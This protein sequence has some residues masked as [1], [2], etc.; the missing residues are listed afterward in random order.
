MWVKYPKANARAHSAPAVRPPGVQ[1]GLVAVG[2][3]LMLLIPLACDDGERVRQSAS[4]PELGDRAS[5]DRHMTPDG[6]N[7]LEVAVR[8]RPRAT[9]GRGANGL[10][11][12][13]PLP[14]GSEKEEAEAPVACDSAA[15]CA[16]ATYPKVSSV[17]DCR[18]PLCPNEVDE[19]VSRAEFEQRRE[20]FR[21]TCQRWALAHP[22]PPQLC[23]QPSKLACTDGRCA[24]AKK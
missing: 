10:L 22:C 5:N 11:R 13:L 14:S 23:S 9:D 2:Y 1:R 19:T 6:S 16:Y 24:L 18:C 4:A 12:P 15:D 3:A 20:A 17:D 21:S 7:A 8:D